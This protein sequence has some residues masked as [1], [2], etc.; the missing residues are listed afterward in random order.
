MVPDKAC[1]PSG[2]QYLYWIDPSAY[3][4]PSQFLDRINKNLFNVF[5]TYDQPSF[6][7]FPLIITLQKNPS[8]QVSKHI[9]SFCFLLLY[10]CFFKIL[11]RI[12]YHIS[13]LNNINVSS[14]IYTYKSFMTVML[15]VKALL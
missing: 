2:H 15:I 11:P 8:T 5:S 7:L 1:L 3:K 13:Y 14:L 9:L 12:P 6:P 10:D 4:I